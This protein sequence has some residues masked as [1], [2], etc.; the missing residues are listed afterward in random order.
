MKKII[1][2]LSP[3]ITLTC[4]LLAGCSKSPEGGPAKS[5]EGVPQGPVEMKLKWTVGKEY[6]Q[7]MTMD[8]GMDIVMPGNPQ[9]V[10]QHMDM[11][12]DYSLSVLKERPEGGVEVEFKF[13]S[14]KVSSKMGAQ[15]LM[16]FDSA[17][18]PANDGANSVAAMFRKLIGAHVKFLMDK[19]G[20]VEKVVGYDEF[21][22]QISA[23]GGPG[24]EMM[25]K[26]MFS[27]DTLKQF[28]ARAQGLPDKP[29]KI[30][31]TWPNHLEIAAGPMGTMTMNM[32]YKFAGWEQHDGHNCALL[33]FTG[34]VTSKPGTNNPAMSMTIQN[35]TLSGQSWFDPALGMPVDNT[36]DQS[37]SVKMN[38]Q[39][40]NTDS[41]MKQ[42]IDIKLVKISDLPK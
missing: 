13:V 36:A 28:G 22:S 6:L 34:D 33:T 27:E 24:S 23:G 40:K 42:K 35:G 19:N 30:G 38:M 7:R 8:Q 9:P 16:S 1:G 25:F 4:L 26:S 11:Q 15:E 39:G 5:M 41:Q 14:Q 17:S 18:D 37:M 10:K 21:M 2:L 3:N 32:K 31:D 29:V 20:K 12:Q